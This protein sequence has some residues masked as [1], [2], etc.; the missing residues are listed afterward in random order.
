MQTVKIIKPSTL[1]IDFNGK[2]ERINFYD[3]KGN[4]IAFRVLN[5]KY[6]GI[7]F[8]LPDV[9]NYLIDTDC[10]IKICPIRI[11]LLKTILPPYQRNEMKPFEIVYNANLKGTPARNFVKRGIIETGINFDKHCKHIQK[12]ILLHE[13]AHFYYINE[14]FADLFA[15]KKFIADGY[16]NSTA[17]YSLTTVLNSQSETNQERIKNL[18]SNLNR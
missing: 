6:D 5:G 11:H 16:N 4:L 10:K 7:R 17:L 14:N 2:P 15:A 1:E 13:I 9:G 3:T 18:F 12:F 8:N